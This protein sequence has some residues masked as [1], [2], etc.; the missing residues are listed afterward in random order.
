LPAWNTYA[1]LLV[2]GFPY[3]DI[4]DDRL[5]TYDDRLVIFDRLYAPAQ[6]PAGAREYIAP[7]LRSLQLQNVFLHDGSVES[8]DALLDP[9]RGAAH[10]MPTSSNRASGPT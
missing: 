10:P 1:P 9:A 6:V 5:R 3:S 2:R 7:N 8:L 4:L